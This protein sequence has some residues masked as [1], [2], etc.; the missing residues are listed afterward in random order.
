MGSTKGGA[1]RGG[2]ARGGFTLIELLVVIAIIAVLIALLLPAV[3]SA[4]EAARRSQCV[5]NLKQ[6]G[7]AMQNYHDTL[8][9]FPI[10]RQ[11]I[12]RPPGD[13]GYPGDSSGTNHR[14]TW[15]WA[16][17]QYIEQGNLYNEVNFSI[18]YSD[19]S[20]AQSTALIVE[21][22]AYLCPSDPNAG[23][24]NAGGFKFHLGNYMVNWGNMH[25]FQ[26][27]QLN[28]FTTGPLKDSVPFLGA[29]FALDKAFGIRDFTD[30]SSNTLLMSEVIC[31]LPLNSTN[32]D[33]RGGLFNDDF[34]CAMFM[35]YTPPNTKTPD[36]MQATYCVYP[37]QTNPVCIGF[38]GSSFGAF[39]AARSY[40]PGGVN[41]L[42]GD[43]RVQFFKSSINVATWRAL[44]TT[45]GG[46]VISSDAY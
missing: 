44:S 2:C 26:S 29:P 41:A 19:P 46:E 12:N 37:Y 9:S 23:V 10:G 13:S 42:L 7:L 33:H 3:Q 11:G 16:I 4:R 8:N 36:Q 27:A 45:M 14:R 18:A 43:G 6:L 5:N 22:A 35:A 34:N 24:L 40:H 21:V 1:M 20:Q 30:G 17:L 38:S 31:G 39:N 25:Y 15:A 32:F 28:P